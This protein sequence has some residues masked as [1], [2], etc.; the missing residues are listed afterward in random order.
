MFALIAIFPLVYI[1]LSAYS[2]FPLREQAFD[3]SSLQNESIAMFL[4][5]NLTGIQEFAFFLHYD[6]VNKPITFLLLETNMFFVCV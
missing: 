1:V 6:Q 4:D 5:L 3:K 2:G